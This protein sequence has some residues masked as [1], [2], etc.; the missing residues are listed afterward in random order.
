M[1]MTNCIDMRCER[2]IVIMFITTRE[3]GNIATFRG[4]HQG[5][6]A[7]TSEEGQCDA[8]A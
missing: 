8:E 6:A 4:S 7:P 2:P 3:Q 1:V 5:K